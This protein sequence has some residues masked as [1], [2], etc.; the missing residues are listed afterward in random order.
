M[1]STKYNV[2]IA[3]RVLL[4]EYCGNLLSIYMGDDTYEVIDTGLRG[5]CYLG[6]LYESD[7]MIMVVT[8][9]GKIYH[10]DYINLK[11]P[12]ITLVRTL[13]STVVKAK[14]D[15]KTIWILYPNNILSTLMYTFNPI[16]CDT[17]P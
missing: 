17:A 12:N 4:V 16:S 7:D 11:K 13:K 6:Y 1:K 5:I 2:L 10:L 8:G 14:Q 15:R 9:E 3:N